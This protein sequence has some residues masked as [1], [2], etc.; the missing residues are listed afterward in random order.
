M[1]FGRNETDLSNFDY[2]L[3][4]DALKTK[5]ILRGCQPANEFQAYIGAP[6]WGYKSWIG[7]LFPKGTKEV[8][9]LGKYASHFN[10]VE[11]NATFYQ[12]HSPERIFAWKQLVQDVPNFKFC[13]KFPQTIS[14]IRRLRNVEIQTNEFYTSI[15]VLGAHLGPLFLQLPDNFSPKGLHDLKAYLMTLPTEVPVFVEA[16]HKNWFADKAERDDLFNCL[17]EL[18]IGAVISDTSGRRDCLHMELTIP[19]AFI[20]FVDCGNEQTD[21][22]RLGEWVKRLKEWKEHGLQSLYF[23]IHAGDAPSLSLYDY[24]IAKLN[25]ELELNIQIPGEKLN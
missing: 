5:S 2:H 17:R 16:R 6:K 22:L 14:H 4:V 7:K 15:S 21:M 12:I 9:F 20:R 24:F 10:S 19:H 3:P 13:P 11:F 23:F 1:H 8:T 18:N 25:Q